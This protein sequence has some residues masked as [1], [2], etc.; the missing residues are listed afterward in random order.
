MKKHNC[1]KCPMRAKYDRAPKSLIGRFWRWHINFCPGW[2]GYVKSLDEEK[3][4]ELTI[5]Y[6]LVAK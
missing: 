6:E 4:N 3:K 5:K 1:E 2:K